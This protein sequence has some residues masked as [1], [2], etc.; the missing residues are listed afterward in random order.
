[1]PAAGKLSSTKPRAVARSELRSSPV[2]YWGGRASNNLALSGSTSREGCSADA[3]RRSSG[4][5]GTVR[6]DRN[7]LNT[8]DLTGAASDGNAAYKTAVKT[9]PRPARSLVQREAL[10]RQPG[11]ERWNLPVEL[12]PGG[13]KAR[14]VNVEGSRMRNVAKSM[15]WRRA[16]TAV[17]ARDFTYFLTTS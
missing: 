7:T 8:G 2:R 11:L 15:M 14:S 13:F 10:W 6:G 16:R 5:A 12:R 17:H 4:V 1:M 3:P 9:R